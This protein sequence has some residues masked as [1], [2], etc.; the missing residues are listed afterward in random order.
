MIVVKINVGG[1]EGKRERVR[2]K[3]RRLDAIE[4]DTRTTGVCEDVEG[5]RVT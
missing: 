1:K 5:D 4:N 2:P 3:C